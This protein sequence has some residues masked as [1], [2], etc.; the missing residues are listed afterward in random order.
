METARKIADNMTSA[1]MEAGVAGHR[2]KPALR[3][4]QGSRITYMISLPIGELLEMVTLGPSGEGEVDTSNRGITDDWVKSIERGL[5]RKLAGGPANSKYVLFPFTANIPEGV[6]TFRALYDEPGGMSDMG[7]LLIPRSI[8]VVYADGRHRNEALRTLVEEKPWLRQESVN[9]FIIEESDVLQ[10]RTDFAD[11]AKVLP[12]NVGLQAWF[13]SGVALNKA[14][15]ELVSQS[16]VIC[17]ADVEK[18]KATVTGQRN[19]KIWTYNSL[20]GYVGTTFVRGIPGKTEVLAGAFEDRLSQYGWDMDSPEMLRFVT[21][22]TGYLD[23][24][25]DETAGVPLRAA[26]AAP[27][28]Q[29]WNEVRTKSWLLKPSGLG[30]F[31]LLVY[32][33]R[34]K[35]KTEQPGREHEWVEEKIREVVQLDWSQS[36]VLF[37]GTLVK[38]GKTQGSST[39]QSHAAVVLATKLGVLDGIPR[40][41]AESLLELYDQGDLGEAISSTERDSIRMARRD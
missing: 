38:G 30:A 40:R 1:F 12:I 27:S 7:I 8:Q 29:D 3:S 6:A 13:D 31:G 19:Q 17:D 15:H 11:G 2:S 36:S 18:F 26:R 32:D 9:L 21:E 10:Q 16:T 34:E 24:A 35:A 25:L 41:T 33:L 5:R 22:V 37:K 39:A 20:R 14:T 28:H 23:I 4:K